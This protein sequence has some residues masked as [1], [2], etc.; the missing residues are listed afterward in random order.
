MQD[1]EHG[2]GAADDGGGVDEF[3]LDSLLRFESQQSP[4]VGNTNGEL[5]IYGKRPRSPTTL[6]SNLESLL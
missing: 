3:D 1:G 6:V 2:A 5:N 4:V